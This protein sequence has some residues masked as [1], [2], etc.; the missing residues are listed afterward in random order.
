MLNTLLRLIPLSAMILAVVLLILPACGPAAEEGE[1]RPV[2]GVSVPEATH[3]WTAGI[4]HWANEAMKKYPEVEWRFQRAAGGAQQVSHIEAMLA[5]GIDALV[6]LPQDA[7]E[8]MPAIRQAKRQGVYVV[9]VDRGL[10]E[11]IADL[12]VAGDNAAFGR[13]AAEFMARKLEGR[14]RIAILRGM[15]VPIDSERYNAAVQVFNRYPDIEI[16]ATQRGNWNRAQAQQVMEDILT[17]NPRIDAVW[18]SDDD[19]ALGAERAIDRAG[20]KDEMWILGGAGMK[21]IIRRVRDND[22]MFPANVTYP[23]SM[24]ATGIHLAVA[25]VLFDGDETRIADNIP[26]DAAIDRE[27]LLTGRDQRPEG[28]R[29]LKI[30]IQLITPENAADFYYPDSPF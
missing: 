16:V 8:V 17:G 1:R 21:D 27:R 25:E 20:R 30:D 15:A 14:G 4:G 9:S 23:P 6:F 26:H 13:I 18:A 28:Q 11:E 2:I 10:E 5:A 3:G 29:E 12:Y 24:I 22:R 7:A 19:M